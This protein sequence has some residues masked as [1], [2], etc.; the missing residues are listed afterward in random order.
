MGMLLLLVPTS[1]DVIY[2]SVGVS[3]SMASFAMQAGLG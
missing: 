2:D 3:R 1:Y